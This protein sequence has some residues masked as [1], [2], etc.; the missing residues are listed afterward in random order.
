ML[1]TLSQLL[2][3]AL[4]LGG[5]SQDKALRPNVEDISA[6]QPQAKPV[7]T[8]SPTQLEHDTGD[9]AKSSAVDEHGVRKKK[10]RTHEVRPLHSVRDDVAL[11]GDG[12]P[13][14]A[15]DLVSM[16]PL[17]SYWKCTTSDIIASP[18]PSHLLS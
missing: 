10:E 13:P 1:S 5:G 2:P 17:C 14:S 12:C 15:T 4:Q 7:Q 8:E 18:A 3:P 6:P 16:I 9:N 11:T